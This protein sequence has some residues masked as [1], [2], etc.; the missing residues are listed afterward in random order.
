MHLTK[1]RKVLG[2]SVEDFGI[3]W[4]WG[5]RGILTGFSVGMGWVWG[6]KFNHHGS[7]G[8]A[9][10]DL[11]AMGCHLSCHMGSHSVTCH[12]TQVNALRFNPSQTGR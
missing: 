1:R 6:L 8:T 3:L 9:L 7:P 11:A 2:I 4:V 12:P 10:N 5:F